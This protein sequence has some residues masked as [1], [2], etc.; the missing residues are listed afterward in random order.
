V[1]RAGHQLLA[2]Q[3]LLA[4]LPAFFNMASAILSAGV[5]ALDITNPWAAAF[6]YA[7]AAY[8]GSQIDKALFTPPPPGLAVKNATLATQG[9]TFP[10][11]YGED[12]W[13][14]PFVLIWARPYSSKKFQNSGRH[15]Y[16]TYAFG[17]GYS[18]LGAATVA[19]IY[20]NGHKSFDVTRL[21]NKDAPHSFWNGTQTVAD[22]LITSFNPS[23]AYPGLVGGTYQKQPILGYGNQIPAQASGLIKPPA[24]FLSDVLAAESDMAYVDSANY[25]YSDVDDIPVRSAAHDGIQDSGNF[26]TQLCD[27]YGVDI[28]E[29]EDKQRAVKREG[30]VTGPDIEWDDIGCQVHGSENDPPKIRVTETIQWDIEIPYQV[31]VNFVDLDNNRQPGQVIDTDDS[32]LGQVPATIDC[33]MIGSTAAEALKAAK[34]W[35]AEARLRK[36]QYEFTLG[37]KYYNLEPGDR[38][39]LAIDGNGTQVRI[40]VFDIQDRNTLG[41]PFKVLAYR[42]GGGTLS[43]TSGGSGSGGT[44]GTVGDDPVVDVTGYAWSDP[45]LEPNPSDPAVKTPG[46][47]LA[48]TWPDPG[49]SDGV[50]IY[51]KGPGMTDPSLF[52]QIDDRTVLGH[53]S[54]AFDDGT[55]ALAF[56]MRAGMAVLDDAGELEAIAED[57]ARGGAGLTLMGSEFVRLVGLTPSGVRTYT[58]SEVQTGINSSPFTGHVTSERFVYFDGGGAKRFPVDSLWIGATIDIYPVPPG[59]DIAD[60]TPISVTIAAPAAAAKD[61][62]EIVSSGPTWLQGQMFRIFQPRYTTQDPTITQNKYRWQRNLNSTGFKGPDGTA[63]TYWY[64]SEVFQDSI[65]RGDTLQI[66]AWAISPDGSISAPL[67]T[68]NFLYIFN[69]NDGMASPV[70]AATT[71][72]LP[73][74]SYS[75]HVYTASANGALPAIDGVTLAVGD[76]LLIKDEVDLTKNAIAVVND[77]GSVGTPFVL[78][79]RD[80]FDASDEIV[81]SVLVAVQEGSTYAD[82]VFE[83]TSDGPIVLDTSDLVFEDVGTFMGGSGGSTRTRTS[84]VGDSSTTAWTVPAASDY[85]VFLNGQLLTPGL[86][87]GPSYVIS[88]TTLTPKLDGSTYALD[89]GGGTRPERLDVLSYA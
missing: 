65:V 2:H 15:A 55:T 25:D 32:C 23:S 26:K 39:N 63:D 87:V 8:V 58:I 47:W 81:P 88:G 16:A 22:S 31:I 71:T 86:S 43:Q 19:E 10:I 48:L 78:T 20:L 69:S 3:E 89:D 56:E 61:P 1:A 44:G 72:A 29:S 57:D 49:N 46:F 74:Y 45:L 82:H 59:V 54:G 66:R 51:V 18:P 40:R 9:T 14:C 37:P 85:D 60:V 7:A 27:F 30:D 68:S 80:D 6:A 5:T 77:L 76:S 41:G 11:V 84:F 64:T 79:R 75:A 62:D 73:A 36:Q 34:R 70:R 12:G 28:L 38:R 53:M 13:R 17:L 52:G 4:G 21:K 35:R 50:P 42:C 33:S 67:T 24:C 83:L